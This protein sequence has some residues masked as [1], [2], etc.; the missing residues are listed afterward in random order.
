MKNIILS[1]H[2]NLYILPFKKEGEVFDTVYDY[3][4]MEYIKYVWLIFSITIYKAKK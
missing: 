4:E 1:L 2:K 3:E